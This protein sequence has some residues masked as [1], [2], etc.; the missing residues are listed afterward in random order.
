MVAKQ[1]RSNHYK[2]IKV[3]MKLRNES[4]RWQCQ[5]HDDSFTDGGHLIDYQVYLV[6]M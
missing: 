4:E 2:C 6:E 3:V 5:W 1:T